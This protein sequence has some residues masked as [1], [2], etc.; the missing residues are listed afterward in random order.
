MLGVVYLISTLL[1]IFYKNLFLP[2]E[3]DVRS[4]KKLLRFTFILMVLLLGLRHPFESDSSDVTN[5][6]N[7]FMRAIEGSDFSAYIERYSSIE[8]GYLWLNWISSKLIHWPQAILI[9]HAIICCY[10]TLGFINRYSDDL[11]FT[12]V[13]FISFGG[14]LF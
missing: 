9:I 4:R 11:L 8:T 2:S 12:I 7:M 5:Y 6:Y 10:F 14:L 13:C 1:I 3:M